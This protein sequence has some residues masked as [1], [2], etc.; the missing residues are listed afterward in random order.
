MENVTKIITLAGARVS[1]G[2][3]QQEAADRMKVSKQTLISWERG[4]V[5]RMDKAVELA[6]MYQIPI[7]LII[8]GKKSTVV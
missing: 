1:A 7:D 6:N 5:P 2:F 3:T 8:F 4:R